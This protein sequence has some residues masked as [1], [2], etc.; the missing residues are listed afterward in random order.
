[1]IRIAT[2]AIALILGLAL[3][4]PA[5]AAD[6]AGAGATYG[7]HHATMAQSTGGYAGIENPGVMH[8]GFS[9]WTGM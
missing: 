3:A 1:M 9:G 2:A 6:T 5:F 4:T 7:Q 8:Q